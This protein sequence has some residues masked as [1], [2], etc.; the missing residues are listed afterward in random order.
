MSVVCPVSHSMLEKIKV[1]SSVAF[2]HGNAYNSP[3]EKQY[4]NR[5]LKNKTTGLPWWCSG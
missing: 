4:T 5:H 3:G 1:I 2:S